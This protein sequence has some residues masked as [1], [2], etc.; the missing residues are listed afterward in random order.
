MVSPKKS[1]KVLDLLESSSK[2]LIYKIRDKGIRIIKY[3]FNKIIK[4]NKVSG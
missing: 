4:I 2:I 1:K 3:Y